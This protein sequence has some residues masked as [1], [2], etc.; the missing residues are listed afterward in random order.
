MA[1]GPN[2]NPRRGTYYVQYW[3][4]EWKRKSVT[5]PIKPKQR[6]ALVPEPKTVPPEARAA[7]TRLA[8]V[9]R[10][11]RLRSPS[12]YALNDSLADFLAAHH[13]SYKTS[14]KVSI[15]NSCDQFT[16]WC[17]AQK[18]DRVERVTADVCA[19]W[20]DHRCKTVAP[21]TLKRERAQLS[22]AWNKARK[23]KTLVDNPWA[24]IELPVKVVPRKRGSWTRD[25]F[26]KILEHSRPWLRDLLVIG[27]HT[28]LRISALLSLKWSD[29]KWGTANGVGFGWVTVR[30]ENDKAGKGYRVPMSRECHEILARRIGVHD[31]KH[32]VTGYNGSPLKNLSG[33]AVAIIRANKRAGLGKIESPNHQMRRTFGRWAVFGHLTGRPIPLTV[34]SSWLGHSSVKTTMLYLDVSEDDSSR[35]MLPDEDMLPLAT[36]PS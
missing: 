27:T 22:R 33:V 12:R 8:E 31:N 34:V 5:R 25:Q 36:S 29:I 15:K 32:V 19:R 18:I 20:L 4:G 26:A 21:S 7:F 23:R 1:S 14:T 3:D 9:E 16:E 6:G 35:F 24:G 28:G 10:L 13:D 11:A 17:E 30:A 2:W